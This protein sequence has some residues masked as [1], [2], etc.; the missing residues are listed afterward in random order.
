MVQSLWWVNSVRNRFYDSLFTY[1]H[2]TFM[3]LLQT[4]L[5]YHSLANGLLNI[6]LRHT[7]TQS[8]S[9]HWLFYDM[10]RVLALLFGTH[11]FSAGNLAVK[12][13][14][15]YVLKFKGFSSRMLFTVLFQHTLSYRDDGNIRAKH[16]SVTPARI[17]AEAGVDSSLNTVVAYDA[18]PNL[19]TSFDESCTARMGSV[20][21]LAI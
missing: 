8:D 14:I 15:Y 21:K 16:F 3:S 10:Q 17:Y 18:I 12:Y 11:W 7:S 9:A 20:S 6:L 2:I 5:F 19:T 1:S 4:G 13:L